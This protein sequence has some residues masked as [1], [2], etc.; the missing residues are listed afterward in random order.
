MR[1][2]PANASVICVPIDAIETSG[3]ATRP[4][5][6]MYMT[7]SPSVISPAMIARPPSQ[8]ISTPMMPTMTVLPAVRRR[9]AGHRLGDVAEQA[10]R[11]LREDDLLA[12]LGGVGLDDAD[13]AERLG[14]PAGDLGVDLAALAEQ[15]PQRPERVGHAAAEDR[16]AR[17]A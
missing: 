8:I 11:A 6:K 4:M 3:A 17:R 9:D 15:R 10:V 5:K 14:E 7:R 16:R 12:L 1:S 13:A 2:S